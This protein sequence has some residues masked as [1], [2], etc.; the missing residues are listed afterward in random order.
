MEESTYIVELDFKDTRNRDVIPKALVWT[1]ST[2]D[3]TVI[4]DRYKV[5][6]SE[7]AAEMNIVISG[8]DLQLVDRKAIYENRIL[9]IEA[10]YDSDTYGDDLPFKKQFMFRVKNLILIAIPLY[11]EVADAIFTDDYVE[12]VSA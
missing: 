2:E 9:T 3:G 10:T 8:D 11:I 4:N 5:S 1:L 12:N 7:L 6:E